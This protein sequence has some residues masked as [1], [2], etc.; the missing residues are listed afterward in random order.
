MKV[1]EIDAVRGIDTN[2]ATSAE[3]MRRVAEVCGEM[4]ECYEDGT[5]E[6][7]TFSALRYALCLSWHKWYQWPLKLRK[8]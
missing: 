3:L 2:D 5:L 4:S 8:E 1:E 6:Q 7:T